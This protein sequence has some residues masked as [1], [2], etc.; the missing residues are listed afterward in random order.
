[1]LFELDTTLVNVDPQCLSQNRALEHLLG[2]FQ[3]RSHLLFSPMRE[4]RIIQQKVSP[5]VSASSR[6]MI[7]TLLNSAVEAREFI[8]RIEYKVVVFLDPNRPLLYRE[9]KVWHVSLNFLANS[10][11]LQSAIVGE[12]ELDS[13]LFLLLADLYRRK[14]GIQGY[15][16]SARIK[17][18]GGSGL[19]QALEKYLD[20]EHSPCLSISDSDKY[21]PRA[22]PSVTAKRCTKIVRERSRIVEY[23]CLEEREV[24]NLIPFNLLKKIVDLDAF[25]GEYNGLL[26]KNL[27][28]WPYLD[29]K[30]GPTLT[31]VRARAGTSHGFWTTIQSQ[32]ERRRRQCAICDPVAPID[33]SCGCSLIGGFGPGL[34]EKCVT[35]V[36]NNPP[37]AILRLL[38]ED[39]RWERIG[40]IAF[41]FAI[42]PM[43]ERA[44]S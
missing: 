33:E 5:H 36:R 14:A 29:L 22:E 31:W 41:D 35:Y 25:L 27:E 13:E 1:M 12:N 23:L 7:Q 43:G 16:V 3:N 11:L 26:R 20:S 8:S 38:A 10:G 21:H 9:G 32:L 40:K 28:V 2:A 17:G 34:L 39:T 42:V 18:G 44:A 19:P 6:A 30:S 24:E 4:L 15:G 37:H